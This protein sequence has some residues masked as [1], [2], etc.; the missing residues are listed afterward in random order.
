MP[1]DTSGILPMLA[2]AWG[3]ELLLIITDKDTKKII[4]ILS[5]KIKYH[6]YSFKFWEFCLFLGSR[7]KMKIYHIE[8][9]SQRAETHIEA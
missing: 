1:E 4:G 6:M 9:T 5:S 2:R 8:V 7:T 3:F